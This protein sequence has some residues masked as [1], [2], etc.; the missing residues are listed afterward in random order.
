MQICNQKVSS[1]KCEAAWEAFKQGTI[2][3]LRNKEKH[4]NKE[5]KNVK[6]KGS[7]FIGKRFFLVRRLFSLNK[8]VILS[9]SES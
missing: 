3:R 2:R 5:A 4:R 9:P 8:R 1:Y 6:H 7:R